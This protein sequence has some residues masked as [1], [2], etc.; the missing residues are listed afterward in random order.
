MKVLVTGAGGFLG[1]WVAKRIVASGAQVRGMVR[2]SAAAEK[3]KNYGIEPVLGDLTN[4]DSLRN[5]IRGVSHVHHIGA[6]FRQGGATPEAFHHVNVDGTKNLLE[7]CMEAGVNR[8]M[9]CSTV[10]VLGHVDNPPAD[11]S[12][13]YNPGDPY[14]TS[15][16]EGEKLFL[17]YVGQNKIRGSVIRPAMI[18]GPGDTRTL[19]LFKQIARKRFF[20]VGPGDSLVHFVDVRDLAEAFFKLGERVD[21]NGEIF[22]IAGESSLPLEQLVRIIASIMGVPRPWL[23]LPVRPMQELG[24]LCEFICR[25]LG[26]EPPLF[27]RRVDFF[28]KDRSFNCQK[29]RSVLGYVPAKSLLQELI[30][31]INCYIATGQ[32][33]RDLIR[34][35]SA[36]VRRLDG[37]IHSWDQDAER[38]YGWPEADAVRKFSHSLLD[39]KFPEDLSTINAQLEEKGTWEGAVVHK[40]RN[41]NLLRMFSRWKLFRPTPEAD[42]LILELN[43]PLEKG[44]NV[45]NFMLSASPAIAGLV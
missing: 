31:I 26:I 11:E 41:G 12:T 6:L 14:Q 40:D 17:D 33:S 29:A 3:L 38:L 45:R 44:N 8:V 5:A 2:N 30:E 21:I 19:K 22:V 34:K 1:E 16:M 7:C 42:P 4:T 18:Y 28:T 32:I 25:P 15:K 43:S 20:Y 39:T 9:H 35:P 36:M 23:H 24:S 27:R 37:E 13:P 10:G